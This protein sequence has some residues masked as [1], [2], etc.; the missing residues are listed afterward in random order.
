MRILLIRQWRYPPCIS[1]TL[2]LQNSS[3]AA[4]KVTI[5]PQP[6]IVVGKHV[7]DKVL[8]QKEFTINFLTQV[9]YCLNKQL[10]Y[11]LHVVGQVNLPNGIDYDRI[12]NVGGGD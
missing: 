7:Q 6:G 2:V 1:D 4:S 12:Y 8:F 11:G 9:Q 10:D 3:H 5:V